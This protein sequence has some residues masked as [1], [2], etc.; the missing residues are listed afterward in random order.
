MFLQLS[1]KA[2]HIIAINKQDRNCS[3]VY[4]LIYAIE[5]FQKE[6]TIDN[7]L[8]L[9]IKGKEFESWKDLGKAL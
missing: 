5:K 1:P 8:K 3:S 4:N 7:L 2:T 9:E 6:T